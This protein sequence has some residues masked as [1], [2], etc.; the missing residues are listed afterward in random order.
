[1]HAT[2]EEVPHDAGL[3]RPGDPETPTDATPGAVGADKIA[4]ND[5]AS[6]VALDTGDVR[7]YG[8]IV[9]HEASQPP[10]EVD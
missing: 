9:L 5:S 6:A 8:V 10:P 7:R 1:V 3:A 4:S 2:A